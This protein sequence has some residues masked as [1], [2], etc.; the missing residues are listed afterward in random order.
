MRTNLFWLSDEQWK[1]IEPHLPTD[2]RGVDRRRPGGEAT[3]FS[4]PGKKGLSG[5]A[6]QTTSLGRPQL[7]PH[8][9]DKP[10]IQRYSTL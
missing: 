10:A 6:A 7:A 9:P 5:H 2:V 4:Y 8:E 1:R 3:K